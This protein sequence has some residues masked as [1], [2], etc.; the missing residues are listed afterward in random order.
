MDPAEAARRVA[1]VQDEFAPRVAYLGTASLG[2][3]PRRSLAALHA[4]VADWRDGTASAPAYDAPVHASRE[5]YARLVG[6]PASW[7][8]Q[9]SQ[10]SVFAGLVAAS[11][12]DGAEVLVA[13]G[14]FTSL[15][16]PFLAQAARGVTVREVPLAAVPDAVRPGTSVVAVSA[17]QSRDGRLVDTDALEAAC[18]QVDARVLLDTTQA[19]GWLPVDARR[20]A[21]TVG[22]GYKWLLAMRGTCFL[23]GQPDALADLVPHTAGWYAGQDP[24]ASIYG[25]PL[26]LADDARRLDV[27]PAWLAWVTQAPSLALLEEVG[28]PAL[29]AHG[30]GL[31]RRCAE[32]L[33]VE[34]GDSA[35]L[36]LD[37][38]PSARERLERAGVAV[39]WPSG[40]LR[41]SFH[42]STTAADV[43]RACEALSGHVRGTLSA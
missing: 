19:T 32:G 22:G 5:A 42:V 23:T 43:D 11:L 17:V 38:L 6:V 36:T 41:L 33:G 9:G 39:S 15:T 25:S 2:L 13:E 18:A 4:A 31:A 20:W 30:V 29:H 24:W 35:V 1:A 3:P 26:R 27:S 28:V 7:V 16:F 34:S 37:A 10:V 14:D 40:V 8:A 12:P 21:W